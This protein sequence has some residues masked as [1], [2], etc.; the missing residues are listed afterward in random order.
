MVHTPSAD[1]S[2]TSSINH[3]QKR[4][5]ISK[6]KARGAIRSY[7]LARAVKRKTKGK[8]RKAMAWQIRMVES[9][10]RRG[11]INSSRIT[12]LFTTLKYNALWF[13]ANGPR[14]YGTDRRFKGSKIIFQ[15]FT[16]K[17]WQ[18]HPL[19]NFSR[20]N[21]VWTINDAPS[22]RAARKY[23]KEL[24]HWG[25][26]RGKALVWE[27]YFPMSGSPAPFI[28]SISQGTAIQSLAR[29]GYRF[30]N[31][32]IKRAAVRGS[33]A[34]N[35]PAANGLRVR[36]DNGFHYLGYSGR[37]NLIILNMFLQSIDAIHDF[38]I[39]LNNRKGRYLFTR[40]VDAARIETPKFDT[41]SWSLYSLNGKKSSL[42]YHLLTITFLSKLCKDTKDDVFCETRD[43]FQSYVD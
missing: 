18:F 4:H 38:A 33:L 14:P 10:A 3:L 32:A 36:R 26:K 28:S 17:G 35:T 27:Y 22:N 23:A 7:E 5:K 24:I 15:Y 1:A 9:M 42:H 11:L 19:S 20:L 21:A 31:Q 41:G 40:G 8:R 30:N 2:V 29:V 39:I 34:F 43:K 13:K 16:G 25:A 37:K 12:P 6:G